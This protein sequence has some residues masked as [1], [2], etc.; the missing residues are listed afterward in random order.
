MRPDLALPAVLAL[1][2]APA[3]GQ[4][5]ASFDPDGNQPIAVG[6]GNDEVFV[7]DD[8]DS[9]I[10]VFDRAGTPLRTLPRPGSSSNDFD[11]DV[12]DD[13]LVLG[14][15]PVPAGSLLASNGDDAPDVVYALDPLTGTVLAS[16]T[17]G[18]DETVGVSYNPADGRLYSVDWTDDL[19]RVFDP[20][21]GSAITSFPVAPAGSPPLDVF[22]GDVDVDA[23][24]NLQIVTDVVEQTRVLTTSGDFVRDF[25][26]SLVSPDD[27]LDLSGIA[28]DN[29]RGEAWVTSRGGLVY[30]LDGFPVPEPAAATLTLAAGLLGL[31]RS[32]QSAAK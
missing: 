7:Y 3:S 28:F 11:L 20:A 9:V 24:G 29:R 26:L 15:T 16:V 17:I 12:A 22:Y 18:N 21:D 30:R 5:L 14:G 10:Q 27:D 19:I 1:A 23:D 8:F 6:Y 4:I 13:P 2:A 31:R 32:R 25:D